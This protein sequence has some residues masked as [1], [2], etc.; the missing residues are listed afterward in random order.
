MKGCTYTVANETLH[1]TS[2]QVSFFGCGCAAPGEAS[3]SGSP[4]LA[5]R[6]GASA[7]SSSSSVHVYSHSGRAVVFTQLPIFSMIENIS[8]PVTAAADGH[9]SENTGAVPVSDSSTTIMPREESPSGGDGAE[10]VSATVQPVADACGGDGSAHLPPDDSMPCMNSQDAS[11]PGGTIGPAGAQSSPSEATPPDAEIAADAAAAAGAITADAAG[12]AVAAGTAVAAGAAVMTGTA[13]AAGAAAAAGAVVAAG[14]AAAA[15]AAAAVDAA[16]ADADASVARPT[17]D[18]SAAEGPAV[19]ELAGAQM[20]A[21][22]QSTELPVADV[23]EPSRNHLNHTLVHD[24]R[25]NRYHFDRADAALSRLGLSNNLQ[26][27]DKLPKQKRKQP[28]PAA[29][30][31]ASEPDAVPQV[32]GQHEKAVAIPAT[33]AV[34]FPCSAHCRIVDPHC[35]IVDQSQCV[36]P[37]PAAM[38]YVRQLAVIL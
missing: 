5:T 21:V 33:S 13:I 23:I 15:G 29:A 18:S 16:V 10:V 28:A 6:C 36:L 24:L 7:V 32:C 17:N 14:V 3:R 9:V 31:A 20:T 4:N 30:A 19:M 2:A 1:S 8:T 35:R 27:R 26:A 12:A 25:K 22:P 11:M 37:D 38:S 34:R